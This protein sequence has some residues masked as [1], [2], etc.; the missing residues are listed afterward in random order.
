MRVTIKRLGQ[1]WDMSLSALSRWVFII[2]FGA[3]IIVAVGIFGL[4]IFAWAKTGNW[5]PAPASEGLVLIGIDLTPV[6]NPTDW[7]GIASLAQWFLDIHMSFW[8]PVLGY[9]IFGFVALVID[10]DTFE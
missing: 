10:G 7:V 2:G 6:Y 3:S 5:I 8:L 1:L 9:L 4:Q